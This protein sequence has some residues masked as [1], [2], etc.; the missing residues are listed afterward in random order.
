[1]THAWQL[2]GFC[3]AMP[4]APPQDNDTRPRNP[5]TLIRTSEKRLFLRG[6]CTVSSAQYHNHRVS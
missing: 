3:T 1:M 4:P 2:A 6:F 5:L